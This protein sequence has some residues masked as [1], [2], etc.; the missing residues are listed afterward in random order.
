MAPVPIRML[1]HEHM[2]QVRQ[3]FALPLAIRFDRCVSEIKNEGLRAGDFKLDEGVDVKLADGSTL[4]MQNAF[5]VLDENQRAVGIFSEHCGYFCYGMADLEL[6][7][8]KGDQVVAR[9]V[10]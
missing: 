7:E 9:H 5:A 8:R 4:S 10:W 2:Q 6:I 1:I 3:A